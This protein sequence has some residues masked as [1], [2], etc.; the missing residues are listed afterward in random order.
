MLRPI[1]LVCT[2]LLASSTAHA[3][4]ASLGVSDIRI[5]LIEDDGDRT[6]IDS[7]DTW[8]DLGTGDIVLVRQTPDSADALDTWAASGDDTSYDVRLIVTGTDEATKI[9][10]V[11]I[12]E[13]EESSS[14]QQ[15]IRLSGSTTASTSWD[16]S[17]SGAM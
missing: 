10:D 2:V 12:D 9:Y 16:I 5:V 4:D 7:V 15:M 14:G 8:F 3:G 13:L 11:S 17:D 1:A 6:R